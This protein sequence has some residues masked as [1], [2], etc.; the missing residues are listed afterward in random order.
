MA[1]AHRIGQKSHVNV[2]RFV[3]K[4]TMEEDV[5]ERAKKKMVLEYA[6]INQMDTSGAHFAP[7]APT[8][9]AAEFSK[10]ELSAI[11]KYGAQNMFKQDEDQLNKNMEEMDLDDILNRAEDHETVAVAGAGGSSLGGEGFLQSLA[12][13]QD[14]KNDMSW[15]DIIPLDAREMFEK[16]EADKA[17][18]DAVA[19][20]NRKRAAAAQMTP[21][22]YGGMDGVEPPAPTPPPKK[23]KGPT[24]PKKTALQRSMELK[25]RDIRVLVRSLQRWGDIRQRFD[26]IVSFRGF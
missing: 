11:L 23:G 13:V 6:I 5:L 19:Q 16:E 12:V 21:G 22:A 7:K 1:R 8:K 4:D 9:P 26:D 24:G 25:E 15:D 10:D 14:V 2:Y 17:T 20:Q 18:A 3:S